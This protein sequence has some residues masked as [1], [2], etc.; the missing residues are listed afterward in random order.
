MLVAH[1]LGVD[2]AG[3]SQ[4]IG[5][6]AMTAKLRQ[7]DWHVQQVGL[8]ASPLCLHEKT[9]ASYCLGNNPFPALEHDVAGSSCN[10]DSA[11]DSHVS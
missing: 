1:Y 7:L 9:A 4:G 6:Q 11:F 10:K 3:H 5:G 8:A 2:H